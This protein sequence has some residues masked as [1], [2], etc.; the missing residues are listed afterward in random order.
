MKPFPCGK[1]NLTHI[2]GLSFNKENDI[3]LI[4]PYCLKH[5][6]IQCSRCGPV[7]KDVMK[8]CDILEKMLF[9]FNI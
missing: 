1:W 7:P 9:E 3:N 6:T 8:K 4:R 2:R 5:D